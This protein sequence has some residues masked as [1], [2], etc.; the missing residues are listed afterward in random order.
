MRRNTAEKQ[1]LTFENY[2]C[3][4]FFSLLAY[5][6]NNLTKET[7]FLPTLGG[8]GRKAASHILGHKGIEHGYCS[9]LSLQHSANLAARIRALIRTIHLA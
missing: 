9:R 1:P 2:L 3:F 7:A 8:M 6:F 5:F 4:V